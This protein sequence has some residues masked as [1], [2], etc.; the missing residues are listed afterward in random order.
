[1]MGR[2]EGGWSPMPP[3][4]ILSLSNQGFL[5]LV[6]WLH[7]FKFYC[8]HACGNLHHSLEAKHHPSL[9]VSICLCKARGSSSNSH[10]GTPAPWLMI[11]FPAEP[12]AVTVLDSLTVHNGGGKPLL[13]SGPKYVAFFSKQ[14][15]CCIMM[16]AW[17]SNN[18]TF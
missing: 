3:C 9:F 12:G 18:Q 11:P 16:I 14:V 17:S 4:I 10:E 6:D 1:M 5:I 15:L 8:M 13:S 2:M 7:P